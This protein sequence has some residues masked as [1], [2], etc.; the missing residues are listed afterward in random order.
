MKNLIDRIQEQNRL[1]VLSLVFSNLALSS[2]K[3]HRP[4]MERLFGALSQSFGTK[5]KKEYSDEIRE[6]GTTGAL[7]SLQNTVGEDLDVLYPEGFKLAEAAKNRG[8]LRALT[9]G[10]KVTSI[11]NSLI[12]RYAKQGSDLLKEGESVYVCDACGFIIVKHETPEICPVCK[13][14]AN[15]F[16]PF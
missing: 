13:A 7:S 6:R 10:K 4:R 15:R 14:P 8:A 5:V 16:V 11:Q 2:Q 3:Q 1:E 9:W 12:R